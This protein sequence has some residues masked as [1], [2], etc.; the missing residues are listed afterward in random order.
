MKT[1][2]LNKQ[3]YEKIIAK[4]LWI[5]NKEIQS[6]SKDIKEG[7][8]VKIFYKDKFLAIGYINPKS[9]I[10]LR[11]LDFADR[12][13]NKDFFIEKIKKALTK[14]QHLKHITNAYRIIHSE[15]DFLP[16]LIVDYYDGYLSIQIN[17]YGMERLRSIII[18][19]LVDVINPKGIYEKSDEKSRQK[20]GLET[21]EEVLFGDIPDSIL[22]YEYSVKFNTY[23]K[24]SQKTG[25]YLDQRKNRKVVSSYVEKDFKVLDLFSNAGGFGIHCS[26]NGADYV[27]FVDISKSAIYQIEEN[28]KL[29]NIKNFEIVKEDVFDFL[30][31]EKNKYNLIILDPPPFAKTKQEKEG[32]LRGY[33][34]LILN[35][36]KILESNGYLAVFSC[37]HSVSFEE[38][39]D[40]TY[41]S[42]KDT[43]SIVEFVEF[44]SQDKDHPY[45]IN[46]PN[47]FY[48]KGA[49]F[50]KI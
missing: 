8:I 47:S 17:T 46:I 30:K 23:L 10:T 2:K 4:N 13:I 20:E 48:L 3:G 7:D 22:I 38:I 32:A 24:S 50:K 21:K 14:R 39:L 29:N 40:I 12:E 19:S 34:Y 6:Y 27:K 43:G 15:A 1:V 9:K 45:I 16:G 18:Q 37:S 36:L 11:V 42:C 44:L 41:Q 35:S 31:K 49:L 26:I 25:F 28:V 5:Y 33:K